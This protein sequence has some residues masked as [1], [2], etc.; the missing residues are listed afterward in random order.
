MDLLTPLKTYLTSHHLVTDHSTQ[1]L[2]ITSTIVVF[3]FLTF[4]NWM[5]KKHQ[6]E[7][8]KKPIKVNCWFCN[9]DQEVARHKAEEGFYCQFDDCGQYNGFN[10]SGGYN[11]VISAQYY[12]SLN[13]R[14]SKLGHGPTHGPSGHGPSGASD[15]HIRRFQTIRKL[16]DKCNDQQ[17]LKLFQEKDFD[18]DISSSDEEAWDREMKKFRN[19]LDK[20]F[21]I[22]KNCDRIVVEATGLGQ[23]L[24]KHI[25]NP[26]SKKSMNGTEKVEQEKP[27]YEVDFQDDFLS[28]N[29]PKDGQNIDKL[30]HYFKILLTIGAIW[31]SRK[32]VSIDKNTGKELKYL[33]TVVFFLVRLPLGQAFSF[34]V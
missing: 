22:C 31:L 24:A 13:V 19:E 2:T 25:V 29:R 11:K 4:L 15:Q 3:A 16:C 18:P 34:P 21:P 6:A 26:F 33:R 17:M 1:I 5:N 7:L 28:T 14:S 27:G 10:D 20:K 8:L 32:E 12:H 30:I 23:A 9:Q